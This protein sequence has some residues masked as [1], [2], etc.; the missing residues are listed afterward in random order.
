MTL[1]LYVSYSNRYEFV[2]EFAYIASLGNVYEYLGY[3]GL[4]LYSC[5]EVCL[6]ISVINPHRTSMPEHVV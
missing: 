2:R 1:I 5:Q 6:G 4:H 3:I